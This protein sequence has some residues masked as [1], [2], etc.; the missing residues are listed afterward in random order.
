MV[1]G[2]AVVRRDNFMAAVNSQQ[3]L[4]DYIMLCPP[5]PDILNKAVEIRRNIR[6]SI[7]HVHDVMPPAG[8]Y[9]MNDFIQ[10]GSLSKPTVGPNAYSD[11]DVVTPALAVARR[12]VHETYGLG[13]RI[14]WLLR[15]GVGG[16]AARAA[17]P[18]EV[19]A[20]GSMLDMG[21]Y[22]DRVDSVL[23]MLLAPIMKKSGDDGIVAAQRFLTASG[24]GTS[25]ARM[26]VEAPPDPPAHTL[27]LQDGVQ[28]M[29]VV[30]DA[31]GR[32]WA[33]GANLSL[34]AWP[35]AKWGDDP[36]VHG[37]AQ[38]TPD[39]GWEARKLEAEDTH[40]RKRGAAAAPEL[41]CKKQPPPKK[42]MKVEKGQRSMSAFFG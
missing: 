24:A 31:E 10:T 34:L 13:S 30:G 28:T 22:T 6:L 26:D 19:K 27:K 8:C 7:S 4:L 9:S 42:A 1:R 36:V 33:T 5:V 41:H 37:R 29:T 2:I 23:T 32:A 35:I 17:H 3:K 25:C 16:V 20:D 39:G 12:R 11:K 15:S 40:K 18:D 38:I 14:P 21:H